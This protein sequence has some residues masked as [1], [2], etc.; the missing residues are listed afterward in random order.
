MKTTPIMKTTLIMKTTPNMKKP[1]KKKMT[2]KSRQSQKRIWP[3][4]EDNTK[5]EDMLNIEGN[6]KDDDDPHKVKE[7][8]GWIA[9]QLNHI[10]DCRSEF[11]LHQVFC[12]YA[13]V[14]FFSRS[15]SLLQC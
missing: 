11:L 7:G 9:T 13:S 2:Q 3:Q 8:A 4:K 10:A 5:H 6:L 1:P 14:S 12:S 15:D